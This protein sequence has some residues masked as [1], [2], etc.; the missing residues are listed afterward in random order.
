MPQRA[1]FTYPQPTWAVVA[2]VG[3]WGNS[4]TEV[5]FAIKD[6]RDERQ[7]CGSE[8]MLYYDGSKFHRM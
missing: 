3:I 5:F 2:A 8:Y 6:N 1:D 4:P 7:L